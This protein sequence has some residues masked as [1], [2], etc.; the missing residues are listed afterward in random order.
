MAKISGPLLDRID[1]HIDVPVVNYKEMRAGFEP[2]NSGSIRGRV[3]RARE[4]QLKRFASSSRV[5]LYCNA[6]MHPRH[7]RTFCELS[8]GCER[9]VERAMTQ[10][11][12]TARGAHDRILKVARTIADLEGAAAIEP[13]HI[14][15]AIQYRTLD[16]TFWA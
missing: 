1:I 5:R 12:M 14:A 9:L 7:I 2:E 15:D 8:S 13:K 4:I 10:H 11:G 6:Q 16:R 3:M